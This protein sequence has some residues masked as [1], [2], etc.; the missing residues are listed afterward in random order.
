MSLP[1]APECFYPLTYGYQMSSVHTDT[2]LG[3]EARLTRLKDVPSRYGAD[4]TNLKV[5][6][7]FQTDSR[8]HIKVHRYSYVPSSCYYV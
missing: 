8:L 6:V 5:E 7:E 2:D 3:W 4:V 1:K